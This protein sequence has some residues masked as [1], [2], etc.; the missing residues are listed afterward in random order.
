MDGDGRQNG[1]ERSKR[2]RKR[3]RQSI[4]LSIIIRE[5]HVQNRNRREEEEGFP[6]K[7]KLMFNSRFLFIF[8]FLSPSFSLLLLSPLHLIHFYPFFLHVSSPSQFLFLFITLFLHQKKVR[9]SITRC[10]FYS[11][12]SIIQKIERIKE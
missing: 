4:T 9:E 11:T 10:Y 7:E 12:K 6:P 1:A 2:G 3:Q 5:H 8:H